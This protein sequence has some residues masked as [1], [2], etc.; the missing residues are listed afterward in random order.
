M[1][2]YIV[3]ALTALALMTASLATAQAAPGSSDPGANASPNSQTND[4]C[5]TGCGG[6]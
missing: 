5:S 1:R 2:S 3:A 4:V 6:G